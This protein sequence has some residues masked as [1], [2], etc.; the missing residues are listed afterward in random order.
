MTY[1]PLTQTELETLSQDELGFYNELKAKAD[2]GDA[3]SLDSLQKLLV[4]VRAR[5]LKKEN[6]NSIENPF[7]EE[8]VILA[9]EQQRYS[10]IFGGDL[11]LSYF[12]LYESNL[13]KMNKY[14]VTDNKDQ[15]TQ[16]KDNVVVRLAEP[17]KYAPEV[18]QED[19]EPE[20]I[21]LVDRNGT[22]ADP[23]D[24]TTTAKNIA[25]KASSVIG[26]DGG[27]TLLSHAN[28]VSAFQRLWPLNDSDQIGMFG[29]TDKVLQQ[30]GFTPTLKLQTLSSEP[31]YYQEQ[32]KNSDDPRLDPDKLSKI[33]TNLSTKL[34]ASLKCKPLELNPDLH[35]Y[36]LRFGLEDQALLATLKE[37]DFLDTSDE[38]KSTLSA[39]LKRH[40]LNFN[41]NYSLQD[42]HYVD[43]FRK[44]NQNLNRN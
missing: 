31:E 37:V 7:T 12:R 41:Q 34:A 23:L 21:A 35:A 8:R 42:F 22:F 33:S 1:T 5:I 36:I 9:T 28:T 25:K 40:M 20:P 24:P 2:S 14:K 39:T 32:L 19:G 13:N 30:A 43:N 6:L 16:P 15:A 26:E 10:F 44:I 38:G 11:I 17:I 3:K 4:D 27:N 18:D 29:V